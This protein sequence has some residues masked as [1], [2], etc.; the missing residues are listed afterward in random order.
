M[1]QILVSS[2]SGILISFIFIKCNLVLEVEWPLLLIV[3]VSYLLGKIHPRLT[4]LAYVLTVV[5]I[6]NKIFQF[7]FNYYVLM[8]L[9]GILH[10]VEGLLTYYFGATKSEIMIIYKEKK[11]ARGYKSYGQWFVPLLFF[12]L[13]G[14][15][16]PLLASIIYYNETFTY[17]AKEKAQKMGIWIG[18]FGFVVLL[19]TLLSYHKKLPI[20]ISLVGMS[21]LHEGL[22]KIDAHLEKETPYY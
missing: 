15:Y 2:I 21:L 5:Y 3:V 17:T 18:V 14:I 12:K 10:V 13:Q 9:T 7:H 4:C 8:S 11:I 1:K 19:L 6:I 16:V 20:F 22:F